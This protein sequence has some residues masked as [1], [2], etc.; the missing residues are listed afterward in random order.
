V[1]K[2]GLFDYTR[3]EMVAGGFLLLALAL[4][5]YLS[6][7]IGG[8][9]I[10]PKDRYGVT[11]RFSNV[12]DLKRGAPVKV[13]GVTVGDVES[14]RLVDYV[15]EARL[16]IDRKVVL[17]RDTIA[18]VATAGLLGDAYLSLSPGGSE[19]SLGDGDRIARTEPALNLADLIGR[20]AFGKS[21]DSPST[22]DARP[23]RQPGTPT[24]AEEK[25]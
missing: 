17:P 14:I 11:A 15:A 3:T 9:S 8:L 22:G 21:N 7:S 24:P 18:S 19:R 23:Q 13:A 4:V 1:K 25:R 20:Y 6:I 12:G 10:A 5:G 2:P 16:A